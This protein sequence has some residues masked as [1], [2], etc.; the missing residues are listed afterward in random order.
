MNEIRQG[1]S[2]SVRLEQGSVDRKEK[3]KERR[4]EGCGVLIL[5]DSS[6]TG[7]QG[8]ISKSLTISL[9]AHVTYMRYG[10][11]GGVALDRRLAAGVA[12]ARLF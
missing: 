4:R 11:R 2:G 1:S 8:F 3:K 10:S 9:S 6:M 5:I 12:A 7:T